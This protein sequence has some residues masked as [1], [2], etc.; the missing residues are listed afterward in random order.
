M[1]F[2]N[3]EPRGWLRIIIIRCDVQVNSNDIAKQ[4]GQ[5]L[6]QMALSWV[7]RDGIVTS[8]LIGASK[9]KQILDNIGI[10]G[11]VSFSQEECEKIDKIYQLYPKYRGA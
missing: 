5:T 11:K 3:A 8:V 7:L 4:R 2:R 6:A 1:L 9:P 10:I